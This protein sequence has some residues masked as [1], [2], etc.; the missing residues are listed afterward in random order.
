M[1]TSRPPPGSIPTLTEVVTLA[2]QRAGGTARGAAGSRAGESSCDRGGAGTRRPAGGGV[3]CATGRRPRA[4]R[5][6]TRTRTRSRAP[7]TGTGAAPAPPAAPAP[8]SAP[9]LAT[10]HMPGGRGTACDVS[11]CDAC[12]VSDDARVFGDDTGAA[13]SHPDR[14][15]AGACLGGAVAWAVRADRFRVCAADPHRGCPGC[16]P[17]PPRRPRRPLRP[18]GRLPRPSPAGRRP[19][20]SSPSACSPTC[21]GRSS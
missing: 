4:T 11:G 7:R 8:A 13:A 16:A 19:R 17:H 20:S 9:A 10:A 3:D 6:C 1:S 14:R 18:P 2:G 21:S 5:P 12:A 15:G